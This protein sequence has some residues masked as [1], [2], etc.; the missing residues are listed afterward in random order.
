M[1]HSGLLCFICLELRDVF[2]VTSLFS[3]ELSK[4]RKMPIGLGKK[5]PIFGLEPK[6]GTFSLQLTVMVDLFG[7]AR[8]GVLSAHPYNRKMDKNGTLMF[9][10]STTLVN[11]FIQQE[12]S[13]FT[14]DEEELASMR[15]ATFEHGF[16]F[17]GAGSVTMV[18]WRGDD[19]FWMGFEDFPEHHLPNSPGLVR[20]SNVCW[21]RDMTGLVDSI[22]K[23]L[24]KVKQFLLSET[25][26]QQV[27]G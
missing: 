2:T 24:P 5:G 9:H 16:W 4:R 18:R 21:A 20:C 1:G 12:V 19:E 22:N 26:G 6:S 10:K 8:R 17:G 13:P 14:D 7:L 23:E 27:E 3:Q 25:P 11:W 15:P